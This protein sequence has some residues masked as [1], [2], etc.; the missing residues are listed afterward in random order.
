MPYLQAFRAFLALSA[1]DS[2]ISAAI[3]E[4]KK[5]FPVMIGFVSGHG[6]SRAV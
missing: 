5:D 4:F 6:F 1:L 3:V 2:P